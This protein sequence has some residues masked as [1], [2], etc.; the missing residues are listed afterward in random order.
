MIKRFF[1]LIFSLIGLIVSLPFL[2]VAALVVKVTSKGPAFFRQ[3]RIGRYGQPFT[4]LKLRTMVTDAAAKGPGVSPR[5]D[6]RETRIGHF[7]RLT[8]LDELPQLI[9]ILK[10]EMSVVGPRPEIPRMVALYTPEQRKVLEVRPGL[11][12]PAQ[13]IGR[14]EADMLP[15][16][17]ENVEAYYITHLLPEKLKIDLAYAA[18]PRVRTDLALIVRSLTATLGGAFRPIYQQKRASWPLLFC[19]DM[20]LVVISFFFAYGLRF[21]WSIPRSELGNFVQSLPLVLGIC[22][23]IFIS[24]RLY[25]SLTKYIGFADLFHMAKASTYS[26]IA[27]VIAIFFLGW[28][29]HSRSIF[30]IHWILM[31]AAMA[32]ARTFLRLQSEKKPPRDYSLAK[33]VLVVGAGDIGDMLIREQNKNSHPFQIVGFID[34]DPLKIGTQLQG[35]R[36]AGNRRLIPDM[37]KALRAEEIYIA[38]SDIC[39]EEMSDILGYIEQ[40]NLKYRVVPAIS[41]VVSGRIHLSKVREVDVSDLIGRRMLS[42]DLGAIRESLSRKRILITG[43]G[44]SIGSELARQIYAYHPQQLVL[45]DR[46]ENYLFELQ[47]ELDGRNGMTARYL[48]GDITDEEKMEQVFA[49]FR[50]EIVFHTAAQKHVP[51]SE[52][53]PDEAIRNNILGSR[54]LARC[55]DRFEVQ[56]FVFVSTDKA[57]NPS[58]VMGATKRA[59]ELFFQAFA[60]YS[61][62]RFITV[63]FGNVL[64]SHGSV[65]PLFMKQIQEGGPITITDKRIER[66]FMSIPEAVNLIL[67]AATFGES[68]EIYILNMGQRVKIAKL[69]ADMIRLAG[70]RPYADID[71]KEVGL[72]PGE[73]L[74][75]ELVGDGETC[76]PTSHTLINR[77]LPKSVHPLPEFA[78]RVDWLIDQAAKN[79][80]ASLRQALTEIVPE[81]RPIVTAPQ[82]VATFQ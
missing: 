52:S 41:D 34:D 73:K 25:Q 5:H 28:R 20:A 16:N 6:P 75:E 35:I 60:P 80:A 21:D 37:A 78:P 43:A 38:I 13:I 76:L 30:L 63:R 67:Q 48:L 44:G 61:R 70:F 54:I 26:T 33:R 2:A 9:N 15:D 72:R 36:V 18:K 57:V 31:T 49:E 14:N 64:N 7:L 40:T 32:V 74:F 4:L 10:G 82:S 27:I 55:A 29:E 8:K 1:D 22:G 23:T 24:M 71:I 69:A 42:L 59:V 68:G 46:S 51:L 81:Y 47:C 3:E 77:V 50:P 79:N 65:V 45:L 11:V 12:G 62:T 66:F 53:N 17:L 39:P 19:I 58:S 56:Q